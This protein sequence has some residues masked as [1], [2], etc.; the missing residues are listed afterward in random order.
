[1]RNFPKLLEKA[2]SGDPRAFFQWCN[3]EPREFAALDI[4]EARKQI[5]S[6]L[7]DPNSEQRIHA[8]IL[9]GIIY[10]SGAGIASN[11]QLAIT[12]FEEAKQKGSVQALA[13]LGS[14]SPPGSTQARKFYES[15]AAK[16]CPIANNKLGSLYQ[17]GLGV[18]QDDDKA[19]EYYQKAIDLEYPM[20]MYNRAMM[21]KNTD[22]SFTDI[23][24]ALQLLKQAA[25]LGSRH[26]SC[27]LGDL[28]RLGIQVQK[29]VDEA[30]VFYDQAIEYADP[31]AMYWKA[32]LLIDS[33]SPDRD[34][35]VNLLFKSS[36]AGFT[37]AK[38]K[39]HEMG[40]ERPIVRV[41]SYDSLTTEDDDFS[42]LEAEGINSN[43]ADV[44]TA[45]CLLQTHIQTLYKY[46]EKLQRDGF[47]EK[48]GVVCNFARQLLDDLGKFFKNCETAPL[49]DKIDDST[50]NSALNTHRKIVYPILLNGLIMA[51]IIGFFLI[52]YRALQQLR[53][54]RPITFNSTFFHAKTHSQQLKEKVSDAFVALETVCSSNQNFMP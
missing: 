47:D 27:S 10:A 33:R 6:I 9:K 48:G 51:T 31:K 5:D 46:G 35:I 52:L 44:K 21:L 25:S 19:I 30:Q 43:D 17:H 53:S 40:I 7:R 11:R 38:N 12:C 37:P 13:C 41:A 18:K 39:L 15:G 4:Q 2:L 20:A 23:D 54:D 32:I 26:A 50:V 14:I 22:D 16:G 29:N 8:L 1:M 36:D 42:W 28:Y 34:L 3:Y 45:I 49:K 24:R